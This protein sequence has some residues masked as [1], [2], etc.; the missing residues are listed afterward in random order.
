MAL[1]LP[2][3]WPPAGQLPA[4][5]RDCWARRWARRPGSAR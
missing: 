3:P 4:G 1:N 5:E 2:A